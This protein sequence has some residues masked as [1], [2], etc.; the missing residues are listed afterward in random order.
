M[1]GPF[2]RKR[3]GV[4]VGVEVDGGGMGS[5]VEQGLVVVVGRGRI[6]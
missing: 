3:A 4:A 1:D 5:V 6:G 2:G